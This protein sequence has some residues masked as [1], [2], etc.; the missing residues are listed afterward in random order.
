ML[1]QKQKDEREKDKNIKKDKKGLKGGG[2]KGYDAKG[3]NQAMINDVMGDEYDEEDDEKP[4]FKR[5]EEAE[6]DFMWA[7]TP[8]ILNET[9]SGISKT[10]ICW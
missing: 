8:F 7:T 3:T 6:Y 9:I 2:G 4:G 10:R 5:A 1:K